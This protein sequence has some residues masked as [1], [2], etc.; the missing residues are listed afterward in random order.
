MAVPDTFN[1][2]ALGD[3]SPS[4]QCPPAAGQDRRR[5]GR[6]GGGKQVRGRGDWT[7]MWPIRGGG[8][9]GEASGDGRR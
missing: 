2:Q 3:K 7:H 8:S 4:Q 9:K 5:Q 6:A 1:T